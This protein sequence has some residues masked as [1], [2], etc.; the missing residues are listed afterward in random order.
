MAKMKLKQLKLEFKKQV[1][2]SST[3]NEYENWNF[4]ETIKMKGKSNA[5][6][7]WKQVLHKI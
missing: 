2:R 4:L 1:S 6:L 3:K 7:F 5:L